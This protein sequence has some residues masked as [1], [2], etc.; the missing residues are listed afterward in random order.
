MKYLLDTCVVSELIKKNPS[1]K[2]TQWVDDQ[3]ERNLFISLVSI[4]ELLKGIHKLDEQSEKKAMLCCWLNDE[5]LPRFAQRIVML[6]MEVIEVWGK[7]TVEAERYG[8][9]LPVLDSLIAATAIVH[10]LVLVTRNTGDF[11]RCD[12]MIENIWN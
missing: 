3:E 10:K 5:L 1:H 9:K 8:K 6:D 4:G 12:V 7:L 11:S 2:V